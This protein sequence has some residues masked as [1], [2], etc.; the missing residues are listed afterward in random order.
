MRLKFYTQSPGKY[1]FGVCFYSKYKMLD[2]NFA[3]FVVV[4]TW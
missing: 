1:I 2:I 4:I 3:R